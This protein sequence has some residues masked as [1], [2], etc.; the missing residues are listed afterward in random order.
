MRSSVIFGKVEKKN[1][2]FSLLFNGIQ[3]CFRVII[4]RIIENKRKNK[5]KLIKKTAKVIIYASVLTY[6]TRT[7]DFNGQEPVHLS[8]Q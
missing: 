3:P 7:T 2:V 5:G 4:K 1:C 6:G 8:E